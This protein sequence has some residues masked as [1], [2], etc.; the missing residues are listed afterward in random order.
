MDKRLFDIL[1]CPVCKGPLEHWRSEQR[2]VCRFDRLGFAITDGIPV[3]MEEQA[4]QMSADEVRA[5][6]SR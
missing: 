6:D 4:Q 2:L 3:L 5:G 1:A